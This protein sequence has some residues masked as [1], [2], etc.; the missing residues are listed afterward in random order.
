MA[1]IPLLSIRRERLAS[2]KGSMDLEER[3]RGSEENLSEELTT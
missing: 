3:E 2:E 1:G